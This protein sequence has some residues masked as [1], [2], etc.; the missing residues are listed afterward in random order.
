MNERAKPPGFLKLIWLSLFGN[1]QEKCAAGLHDF[2]W[3]ENALVDHEHPK[4]A[5]RGMKQVVSKYI[6]RNPA[7][8][9]EFSIRMDQNQKCR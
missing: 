8:D 3:V 9:E 2:L 6:C 4:L 7:C 5:A 1:D